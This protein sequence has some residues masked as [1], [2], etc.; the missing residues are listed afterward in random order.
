MTYDAD[1]ARP[2]T[3]IGP[4]RML[5]LVR[6][7]MPMRASMLGGGAILPEYGPPDAPHS[8]SDPDVELPGS[9]LADGEQQQAVARERARRFVR[10]RRRGEA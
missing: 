3:R 5:D 10:A 9:N 8:Y 4:W 2:R 7:T 1:G 6:A